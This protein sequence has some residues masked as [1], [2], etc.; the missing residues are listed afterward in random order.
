MPT[1]GALH[2][3]HEALVVAAREAADAVVVS[4][5][6][7]PLQFGPGEDLSSYPRPLELHDLSLL[8]PGLHGGVDVVFTP[9]VATMYP[10]GEPRVTIEPGALATELEGASRPG[11]F[12]GVL[13]VVAKLLGLVGPGVAVFGTKDYQ[14]LVL[15]RHCV[16][17]LC[18][19]VEILDVE[20]VRDP[21]GLALSSRNRRLSDRQR[22]S[23]LA[24]SRALREGQRRSGTG[25]SEAV[26]AAR[27]VLDATSGIDVDYL[28]L[29]DVD[30][31]PAPTRRSRP[32]L[33]VA[34]RV[35][36]HLG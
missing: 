8:L 9:D 5:F 17:D 30:L 29:R 13:T 28:E 32:A 11:H 26:A 16:E 36:R 34:A 20:T 24:L 14:Q 21:D 23:A 18:L 27:A 33:L 12:R 3:G 2:A 25:G 7:N 15:V 4:I 31:G 10:R 35:R 1:L 22:V 6:V 19:P